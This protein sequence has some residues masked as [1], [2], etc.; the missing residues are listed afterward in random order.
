[1]IRIVIENIILL[2]LPTLVYISYIY[3][4]VGTAQGRNKAL[5]DAPLL[6]LF[7][8]GAGLVLAILLTFGSTSGSRPGDV[9]TPPVFRDGKIQPG[10]LDDNTEKSSPEK[11]DP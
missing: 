5:N 4:T 8:I 9:Y 7:A 1:M 10:R 3:L 11:T 6:W 2:L